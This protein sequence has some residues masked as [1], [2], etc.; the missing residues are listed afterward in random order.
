L[1]DIG[2]EIPTFTYPGDNCCHL[3]ATIDFKDYLATP[4]HVGEKKEWD[5][6]HDMT[7]ESIYC[8][9]NVWANLCR[10]SL[11]HC[12]GNNVMSWAGHFHNR[13]L[14]TFNNKSK[15]MKMG[16]YNPN[17]AGALN[18]YNHPNCEHESARVYHYG[19]PGTYVKYTLQD[20]QKMGFEDDTLSSIQLPEGYTAY[21]YERD[22]FQSEWHQD[23]PVQVI[24]GAYRNRETQE[25]RC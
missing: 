18:L 1:L 22:G 14:G 25:L 9:K 6:Y 20:L 13:N 15:A 23:D 21:L 16:P 17:V 2:Q 12:T 7:Y 10:S 11:E 8:G 5:L 3:Y 4:C 19:Q 24:H